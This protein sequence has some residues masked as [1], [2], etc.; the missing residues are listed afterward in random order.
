[1]EWSIRRAI[2]EGAIDLGLDE[3]SKQTNTDIIDAIWRGDEL[4]DHIKEPSVLTDYL[5]ENTPRLFKLYE[6]IL[7]GACR[8]KN[9]AIALKNPES[10]R[11]KG[12]YAFVRFL[13]E[14]GLE[15]YLVTGAVISYD[16]NGNPYGGMYEEITGLGFKIEPGADFEAIE[17][18]TW[19][20]KIPKH[21]VMERL[22]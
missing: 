3:K 6:K 17:G 10:M 21:K 22:C 11:V 14:L 2:E 9:L 7:N 12:S 15:N 16:E 8:D 13:N 5:T 1:M 4:F 18:S 20:N 19:N